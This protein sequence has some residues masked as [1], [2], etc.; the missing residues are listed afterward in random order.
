VNASV[1]SSLKRGQVE[2]FTSYVLRNGKPEGIPINTG[3]LHWPTRGDT[4]RWASAYYVLK[5]RSK[6][7]FVE[8][9][10]GWQRKKPTEQRAV[11]S[12]IIGRQQ[13]QQ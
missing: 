10:T 12:G 7:E 13:W 9:T 5:R 8:S 6:R 4:E 2:G 3:W 11:Y 1:Q